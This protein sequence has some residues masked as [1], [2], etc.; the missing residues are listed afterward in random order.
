VARIQ[1]SDSDEAAADQI[2]FDLCAFYLY[3]FIHSTRDG[4]SVGKYINTNN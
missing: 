4:Q 1:I 3:T 2:M